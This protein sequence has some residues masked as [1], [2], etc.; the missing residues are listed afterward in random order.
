MH[1]RLALE[2]RLHRAP[3]ARHARIS[4]ASCTYR[5]AG[6]SPESSGCCV[7]CASHERRA[8]VL[9]AWRVQG[10]RAMH[11]R[12]V[13]RACVMRGRLGGAARSTS[14]CLVCL[15]RALSLTR[16]PRVHGNVLPCLWWARLLFRM[17]YDPVGLH[18]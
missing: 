4:R 7:A 17:I 8:R 13:H 6:A 14:H 15:A 3:C 12:R 18:Q 16:E 10:A 9:R 11:A 2:S 1:V 5:H